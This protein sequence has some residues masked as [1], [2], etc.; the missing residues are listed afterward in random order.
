[1]PAKKQIRV[2]LIDDETTFRTVL[3]EE[4]RALGYQAD[5]T[6]DAAEAVKRVRETEPD[7]VL[8]DIYMPTSDGLEV[9]DT[10]VALDSPPEIIM[11]T[12]HATVESAIEAMKK[13]A[14][15]FLTKPCPLDQM[16]AVLKKA[17]AHHALKS[18]NQ[19]LRSG[20]PRRNDG[21]IW[22]SSAM[23]RVLRQIHKVAPTDSTVL[24]EGESGTGKEIIAQEIHR[25]SSR[26]SHPLVVVDCTSLR[27]DLLENELFGH[28][29]GAF[30]GAVSTKHGLF[31]VADRG[32]LFLD[33][34]V[35]LSPGLQ[36]KLLRV[37][38]TRSFRRVGG[39]RNQHVDVRLLAAAQHDLREAVTQKQF[40]E[41]LYYRLN[42]FRI[43]LPPLRERPEDIP[44]LV[45]HF[46]KSH[47]RRGASEL[48]INT[49]ALDIL[50]KHS[51]PG[52]VRELK[53]VIESAVILAEG[54]ELTPREVRPFS[55][56]DDS[57]LFKQG[58]AVPTL[59]EVKARYFNQVLQHAGGNKKKAAE[60]AGVSDRTLYRFLKK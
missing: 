16:D 46:I 56:L 43:T 57:A 28:E 40:R 20:W 15:D 17:Y 7:V 55:P 35:E 36:A 51:W 24:I 12:G 48:S 25:N 3:T 9:L 29:R 11:L 45:E 8:L 6:E 50:K 1:M 47:V 58:A 37:I 49:Q 10:L 34:V 2:L 31:E 60:L 53:N 30:T 13:G 19:K 21:L 59:E 5:S 41:D 52:N 44:L 4:L 54:Q 23:E 14:F 42:V 26:A 32:T 39:T 33:E 22:Q 38:E 27:E 18:E